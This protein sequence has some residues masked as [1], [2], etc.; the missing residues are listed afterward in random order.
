MSP[1]RL[2]SARWS[3]SRKF[4]CT[5]CFTVHLVLHDLLGASHT[6]SQISQSRDSPHGF[7]RSR[8]AR[9]VFI[10]SNTQ[11][12]LHRGFARRVSSEDDALRRP[13]LPPREHARDEIDAMHSRLINQG[14]TPVKKRSMARATCTRDKT[15]NSPRN[16]PALI[17]SASWQGRGKR[18]RCARTI[19]EF[20]V[21]QESLAAPPK[22]T[23]K[24]ETVQQDGFAALTIRVYPGLGVVPGGA[25]GP[26]GSQYSRSVKTSCWT[27]S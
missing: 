21:S 7:V 9:K 13:C 4:G 15:V 25:N 10:E 1:A 24:V 22:E 20:R 11:Q 6:S 26:G 3:P 23:C 16:P 17:A 8:R 2:P 5:R 27:V 14:E 12:S 19:L 18:R